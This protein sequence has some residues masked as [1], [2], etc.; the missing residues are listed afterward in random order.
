MRQNKRHTYISCWKVNLT[1]YEK[2][3]VVAIV[4]LIPLKKI[5]LNNAKYLHNYQIIVQTNPFT[6]RTQGQNVNMPN[7]CEF[8]DQPKL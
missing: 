2:S 5:I 8:H 7:T 4:L 3:I 6:T 1:T